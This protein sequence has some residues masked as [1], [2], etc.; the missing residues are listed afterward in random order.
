MASVTACLAS[1]HWKLTQPHVD[2]WGQE[3][4]TQANKIAEQDKK[5]CGNRNTKVAEL[6]K[7]VRAMIRKVTETDKGHRHKKVCLFGP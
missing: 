2:K 4:K 1:Y 6:F 3:V 7:E 5:V